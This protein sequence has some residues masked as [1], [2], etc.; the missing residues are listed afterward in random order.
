MR[1]PYNVTGSERKRLVQTVVEV[2]HKPP[3]YRGAPSFAYTIGSFSIDRFGNLDYPANADLETIKTLMTALKN[4]GFEVQLAEN[5]STQLTVEV[6]LDSFTEE[7]LTNLQKSLP[8]R[9]CFSR[10]PWE[11]KIWESR[12]LKISC[13]FHGSPCMAT[14]VK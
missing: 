4:H 2:L 5:G 13:V 12:Q 6:P 14:K 8:I 11:L 7:A 1:L 9:L 10:S 3:I